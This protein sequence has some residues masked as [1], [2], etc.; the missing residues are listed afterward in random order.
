MTK[1]EKFGV[2]LQTLAEAFNRQITPLMLEG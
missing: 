1:R 2:V